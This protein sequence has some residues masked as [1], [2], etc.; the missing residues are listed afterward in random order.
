MREVWMSIGG[1]EGFY[2]VSSIG[3]VRSLDRPV[4]RVLRG[5]ETTV[6]HKGRVLS[7]YVNRGGYEKVTLWKDGSWKTFQ[8]SRLVGAAFLD[9]PIGETINH[10]NGIKRD[11][12][13]ENLEWMTNLENIQHALDS[14]LTNSKLS[15]QDFLSIRDL[16]KAGM[17]RSEIAER[18]PVCYGRIN[19]IIRAKEWRKVA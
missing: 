15:D 13:P 3:R 14:G 10:K 7:P 5:V 16:Y 11:N 19:E 18:F 1:F 6:T 2:E 17:K 9:G 12:R 8:V 4:R